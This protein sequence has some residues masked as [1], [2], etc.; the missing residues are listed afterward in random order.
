MVPLFQELQPWF[1]SPQGD[2]CVLHRT[3][4]TTQWS[5]PILYESSSTAVRWRGLLG[6]LRRRVLAANLLSS[7]EIYFPASRATQ[8]RWLLSARWNTGIPKLPGP[9][10][11]TTRHASFATLDFDATNFVACRTVDGAKPHQTAGD[12]RPSCLLWQHIVGG[13]GVTTS[14][15]L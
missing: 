10:T 3:T 12:N 14:I 1:A 15:F 5:Q 11:L 2:P 13:E 6:W 8:H 7:L 4:H 9:M